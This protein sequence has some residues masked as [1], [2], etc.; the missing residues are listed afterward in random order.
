VGRIGVNVQTERSYT[1]P[2]EAKLSNRAV[3]IVTGVNRIAPQVGIGGEV[4][5]HSVTKL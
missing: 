5:L 4:S 1:T 2:Y 3:S